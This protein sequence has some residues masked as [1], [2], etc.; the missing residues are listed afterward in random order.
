MSAR[1]RPDPNAPT[2]LTSHEFTMARLQT[3]ATLA[4]GLNAST[5]PH[6]QVADAAIEQADAL[7]DALDIH[8]WNHRFDREKPT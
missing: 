1:H 7:L 6:E 2:M 5:R 4:A 3:A 8:P